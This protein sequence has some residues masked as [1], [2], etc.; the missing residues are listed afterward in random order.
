MNRILL[1]TLV[2]ATCLPCG[3]SMAAAKLKMIGVKV[4]GAETGETVAVE[5]G[6]LDVPESREKSASRRLLLPFYRLKSTADKPAAAIFLLAGG[7][8][9]SWIDQVKQQENFKEI[10]FYQSIADVVLFDQRGGGHSL[11][12]MNCNQ[13]QQFTP[14]QLSSPDEI[15]TAFRN[16]ATECRDHWVAKYVNLTAYNT[17][18]N[19]ADVDDM[20]RAFGYPSISLI[21][22]SYGS[23]LALQYMKRYPEAVARV[24]LHGVEGPDHTWDDPS[25][26]LAALQRIAVVAEQSKELRPHITDDGLLATFKRVLDRL[27][28]KPQ[29]ISVENAGISTEVIVDANLVR[30]IIR[31]NAGRRSKPNA[32]PEMILAMERG[33]FSYAASVALRRR[34][35]SL[36][37]PMHYLMDC[38]SGISESRK[39]RYRNDP[40]RELLGDINQEYEY[41]C[42]LWP[43]AKLGDAFRC[44]ATGAMPAL[45]LHGTWDISTPIENAREVASALPNAHLVEVVGGTH[46]ALYNLYEHWPPFRKL[47]RGFLA[48]EPVKFPASVEMPAVE[49]QAFSKE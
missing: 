27:E 5:E 44:N 32:W 49:F 40:A 3:D 42:D 22:G 28:A 48:G 4:I 45:I 18:E 13:T 11:P 23:H 12:E 1:L 38:S 9:S 30:Q 6:Y 15:K 36:S 17:I 8:G 47:L 20:R 2:F 24:V 39:K 34:T 29:K 37:D 31:K 21:G 7:P 16:L 19:A 46:G 26:I 10:L 14:E 25:G 43:V 35:L 33:D 41:L